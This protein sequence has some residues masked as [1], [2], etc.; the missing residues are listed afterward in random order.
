MDRKLGRRA[1]GSRS[2]SNR[3]PPGLRPTWGTKWHPDAHSDWSFQR[4]GHNRHGPHHRYKVWWLVIGALDLM[5]T[6]LL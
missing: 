1:A 5:A 6:T 4:F 2:R 3:M